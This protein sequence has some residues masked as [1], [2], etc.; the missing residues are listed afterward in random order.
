MTHPDLDWWG[1][2]RLLT[3]GK[4]KTRVFYS[5]TTALS[6]QSM[7]ILAHRY[8]K[9]RLVPKVPLGRGVLALSQTEIEP[10]FNNL[11]ACLLSRDSWFDFCEIHFW[12][13]SLWL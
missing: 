2:I 5:S 6:V 8:K 13:V 11:I 9:S 7:R 10:A 4:L 12:E 1:F 3:W